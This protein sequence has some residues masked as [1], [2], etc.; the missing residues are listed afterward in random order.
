MSSSMTA[1]QKAKRDVTNDFAFTAS[2]KPCEKN[3]KKSI[4]TVLKEINKTES[5]NAK[6]IYSR[7]MYGLINRLVSRNSSLIRTVPFY[8]AMQNARKL[9]KETGSVWTYMFIFEHYY[10]DPD[11]N[12]ITLDGYPYHTDKDWS[13]QWKDFSKLDILRQSMSKCKPKPNTKLKF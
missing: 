7:Y 3:L 12:I 9:F 1:T 13:Q 5:H 6:V 11:E 8:C 10:I 4:D 2:K